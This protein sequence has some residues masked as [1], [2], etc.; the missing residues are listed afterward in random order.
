MATLSSGI[1]SFSGQTIAIL[2]VVGTYYEVCNLTT[3]AY[4]EIDTES[5]TD[6]ELWAMVAYC[7]G[8]I[9]LWE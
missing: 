1:E 7:S 6:E 5:A 8:I 2:H 9:N 4:I 3:G